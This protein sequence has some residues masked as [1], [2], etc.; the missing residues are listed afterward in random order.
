ML[1][2]GV[3]DEYATFGGGS[4]VWC[5]I[6]TDGGLGSYKEK[7]FRGMGTSSEEY[8]LHGEWFSLIV[9]DLLGWFFPFMIDFV[10]LRT[11]WIHEQWEK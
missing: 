9:T 6:A 10:S 5:Q 11:M 1:W 4:R 8:D 3:C 2:T 7:N